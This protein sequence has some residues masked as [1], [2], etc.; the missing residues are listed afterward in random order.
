MGISFPK[1]AIELL[2]RLENSGYEAWIVGGAV[3]DSLLGGEVHD[4]DITTSAPPEEI[5]R[6]FEKEKKINVG[7]VFGTVRVIYKDEEYEITTYR[8]DGE[9]VDSR[10]PAEVIYSDNVE[11]DLKRRDFTINAM[12]WNDKRGLIDLFGGI[13]DLKNGVVR[14][15]GR[16]KDRI[17]EDALR[18]LRAVRFSSRYGFKIEE[19]LKDSIIELGE[20]INWVSEERILVELEMLLSSTAPDRAIE[21]LAETKLLK[22]ILPEIEA[23]RSESNYS[24]FL[25]NLTLKFIKEIEG[26]INLR[27]AALFRYTGMCSKYDLYNEED[28]SVFIKKLHTDEDLKESGMTA[29]RVLKRLKAS[30]KRIKT[31]SEIVSEYQVDHEE[32]IKTSDV[33]YMYGRLRDNFYLVA[34]FLKSENKLFYDRM[35]DE[36][37]ILLNKRN[38]NLKKLFDY[39]LIIEKDKLVT[40]V[41]DLAVTGD[42]LL[43]CGIRKGP[44]IGK[45]LNALTKAVIDGKV[46]NS[47]SELLCYAASM[48]ES[49]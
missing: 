27:W 1:N 33:Q 36:V 10:H 32:D 43:K 44:E 20:K 26:N 5:D 34:G 11:E 37:S 39:G 7:R 9:Y 19:T 28:I 6:V 14:A 2:N 48:T 31:V 23:L 49:R 29:K 45:M 22:Y 3:R 46:E 21:S 40:G 38:E 16:S 4:I 12:A 30:T 8:S 42:D 15:V 24:K 47:R 13:D 41:R 25:Y 35:N 18:M 17:N